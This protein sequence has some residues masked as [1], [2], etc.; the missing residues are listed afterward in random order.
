MTEEKICPACGKPTGGYIPCP[1]CGVD[2]RV[3]ISI[4]HVW[5]FCMVVLGI[6]GGFFFLHLATS[7]VSPLPIASIDSWLDYSYAWIEGIVISGPK[8]DST[9]FSFE[10][11]DGSSQIEE[12]A[13]IN[14]EVYS[15]A[16]EELMAKNK[17]P[18]VGDNVLIFGQLRA[19]VGEDKEINLSFSE[20]LQITEASP[21]NTTI[22]EIRNS[23]GT[24]SSLLYHRV[25]VEGTITGIN[26]YSS[27]KIYYISDG[28][29]EIE[30]YLHNG[31]EA[32]V[33]KQ[34]PPMQVLDRVRIT[35][36]LS[37]YINEPQLT[38]ADYDEIEVLSRENIPEVSLSNINE[39]YVDNYVQVSGQIIFVEME[40]TQTDLE[41]QERTVWLDNIENPKI[42]VDEDIFE[43]LSRE[44]QTKIK[45]GAQL[46][47]IVKVK[48]TSSLTW[49]G[50]QTPTIEN[51][52]YTP[53]V[54]ENFS[55]IDSNDVGQLVTLTGKVSEAASY[56]AGQDLPPHWTCS[57]QDN[58]GGTV[59]VYIPNFIYERLVTPPE[60]GDTLRIVGKVTNA[61][62]GLVVQPGVMDDVEVL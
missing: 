41:I 3:K 54:I 62:V 12:E 11:Y 45:R 43:L 60:E 61:E 48:S 4:K 31:L 5:I 1:H 36:G 32:Y 39:N 50:P 6:G 38:V 27:S 34:S 33:E 17:I 29:S 9:S 37:R 28:S 2:P 51:G 49:V 44:N 26:P 7:T 57:L 14:V 8:Y 53:P 10:V 56:S 52:E 59:T 21:E 40:G 35:A 42:T 58:F 24:D 55:Q 23:W 22:T 46:S 18:R 15:P 13:T 20:D 16:F 30:V 19:P 25:T 47:L